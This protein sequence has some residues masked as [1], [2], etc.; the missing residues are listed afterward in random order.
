MAKKS[1]ALTD[2]QLKANFK[3]GN[4]KPVYL[5]CGE[6]NHAIDMLLDFFEKEAIPEECQGFDLD[7]VYGRD[8]KMP[9]LIDIAKQYPTM[10]TSKYR[11]ILVR[12]A[13]DVDYREWDKLYPYLEHPSDMSVIVFC[14]RDS[15]KEIKKSRSKLHKAISAVG[16]VIEKPG[17]YDNR[18]P[19]WIVKY[20]AS[21]GYKITAQ[22]A[23]LMA[24]YLGTNTSKIANELSKVFISLP[25]GGTVTND[26]IERNI[27]IS[28]EYNVFELQKALGR[29]DV[30]KS[31]RIVNHFA[32]NPKDNPIQM[33]LP[34]L[35]NYFIKV[36]ICQQLTDKS[37]GA[38]A[39][40][41]GVNPYFAD[42]YLIAASNYSLPKMAAI[43]GYL[44]EAD[45]KSKGIRNTGTITDGELI[46]ELV[47]KILH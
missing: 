12:E 3:S 32:A 27:G 34:N 10:P 26:I 33:I 44:K 6:E 4:V 14:Y 23:T 37:P 19:D 43:I 2:E 35:Y 47:F 45:L 38:V 31:N 40:A 46:K 7:V 15:E 9:S 36:M 8:V 18:V 5:L 16:E 39:S 11:L 1:A 41:V 13:Q 20:T 25:K 42:D 24:E 17:L 29:R 21:Q 30:K 22:S 28:K